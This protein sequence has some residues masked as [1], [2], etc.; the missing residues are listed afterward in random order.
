MKYVHAACS[1]VATLALCVF[2]WKVYPLLRAIQTDTT[3]TEAEMA[4]VLNATR[5]SVLTPEQVKTLVDKAGRVL[6]NTNVALV[7]ASTT[8]TSANKSMTHLDDVLTETAQVVPTVNQSVIRVTSDV[9]SVVKNVNPLLMNATTATKA[10]ALAMSDPSIH[11]TLV[12]VDNTS[13]NMEGITN[14]VHT[15][16]GLIVA[17]TKDAFKPQ[18]KA[19]AIAK[20]LGGGTI[21]LAELFYYLTH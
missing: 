14:D 19:L 12:H 3:R 15:E 9:D 1:I 20:F 13:A 6:D 7:N 5:K 10:A 18:N 11:E 16:T 2:L 17:R 21:S 8:I 4:G